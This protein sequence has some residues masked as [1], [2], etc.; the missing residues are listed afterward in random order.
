MNSLGFY[1]YMIKCVSIYDVKN[2]SHYILKVKTWP[3]FMST[4]VRPV[5]SGLH[6]HIYAVAVQCI[7]SL[8]QTNPLSYL[9]T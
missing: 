6:G 3:N 1:V 2:R 8:V 7:H 4:Y 9:N 5:F